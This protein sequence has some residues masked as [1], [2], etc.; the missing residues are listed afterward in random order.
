MIIS[1]LIIIQTKMDDNIKRI[2]TIDTFRIIAAIFVIGIHSKISYIMPTQIKNCV[3]MMFSLAVPF[4]FITSG[5]FISNTKDDV[6]TDGVT[7]NKRLYNNIKKN[8]QMYLTWNIIY[9]PLSIGGEIIYGSSIKNSCWNLIRGWFLVGENY[10]S[11]AFWYLLALIVAETIILIFRKVG[12]SLGMQMI[13]STILH[14]SGRIL[15]YL[16]ACSGI[17]NTIIDM[18]FKVFLTTRNG[19]FVGLFYVSIGMVI[20]KIKTPDLKKTI[21]FLTISLLITFFYYPNN[22]LDILFT[23]LASVNLFWIIISVKISSFKGKPHFRDIA[24][25]VYLIHMYFLFWGIEIFKI[26]NRFA[27]FA[28]V[29]MSSFVFAELILKIQC[30]GWKLSK[31]LHIN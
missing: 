18:Y 29:I 3:D 23:A 26:N 27:L 16:H 11:W 17:Q 31:I 19:L 25:T 5:Y 8:I 10:Y 21:I 9:L 24:T 1:F 30:Y 22:K 28:M 12:I 6:E 20:R 13:I 15:D 7:E 14:I 2:D 4:F